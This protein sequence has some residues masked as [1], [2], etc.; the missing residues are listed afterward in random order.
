MTR[1]RSQTRHAVAATVVPPSPAVMQY[2]RY[3]SVYCLSAPRR[4][5]TM[6]DV[7]DMCDAAQF[8]RCAYAFHSTS[9]PE[10]DLPEHR[11]KC[12]VRICNLTD[13]TVNALYAQSVRRMLQ[14]DDTT[15][16]NDVA[17]VCA[18]PDKLQVWLQCSWRSETVR[19]IVTRLQ[20]M[21]DETLAADASG[22]RL[23]VSPHKPG[24]GAT[25]VSRADLERY[26]KAA[27][28]LLRTLYAL[29]DRALWR[30]AHKL[31][32]R[33]E[34]AAARL[35]Q[36]VPANTSP[37]RQ[38]QLREYR[39]F[40]A[41]A[42]AVDVVYAVLR[43]V[44]NACNT[45]V[46][47]ADRRTLEIVMNDV[48]GHVHETT[49][50]ALLAMAARR[51]RDSDTVIDLHCLNK[52]FARR[53]LIEFTRRMEAD[54]ALCA[55]EA[56]AVIITG[57]GNHS[58]NGIPRLRPNV[59]RQLAQDPVLKARFE[60][61]PTDNG[62]IV[63]FRRRGGTSTDSAGTRSDA[64][65]SPSASCASDAFVDSDSDGG[66]IYWDARSEASYTTDEEHDVAAQA[67]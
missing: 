27:D 53:K 45:D 1:I 31:L 21:V 3:D 38:I 4:I 64:G 48:M 39:V 52:Q 6:T 11:G 43:P 55:P 18:T 16:C 67:A 26:P 40:N 35:A 56:H 12:M 63:C 59:L 5:G 49:Y 62:G 30:R 33:V 2:A 7:Y 32:T 61:V 36:D 24:P 10:Y 57:K 29:G 9:Q 66:S 23:I 8:K 54:A 50:Q 28:T 37:R 14:R 58:P 44:A 13:S 25:D 20:D 41:V 46:S 60:D 17:G 42:D 47:H 65:P 34:A 51:H 15:W 22:V 19:D